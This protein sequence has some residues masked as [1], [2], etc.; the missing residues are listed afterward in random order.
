MKHLWLFFLAIGLVA[1]EKGASQTPQTA[2]QTAA[3]PYIDQVND[4][5]KTMK[6]DLQNQAD[7]REDQ[8]D[9]KVGNA[10]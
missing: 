9:Q 7:G 8:L 5:L 1:C 3:Q 4:D 6:S 10:E 2:T